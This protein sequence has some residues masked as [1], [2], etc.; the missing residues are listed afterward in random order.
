MR[1]RAEACEL[2]ASPDE[3]VVR[4]EAGETAARGES[5]E[6]RL[7]VHARGHGAEGDRPLLGGRLRRPVDVELVDREAAEVSGVRGDGGRSPARV[8]LDVH[9]DGEALGPR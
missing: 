4:I 1:L 8:R 5:G 3:D 9:R 6:L 7:R 2:R